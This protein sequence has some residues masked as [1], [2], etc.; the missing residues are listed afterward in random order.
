M[1]VTLIA[2]VGKIESANDVGTYGFRLVIL[3]P[4]NIG[5]PG[6]ASRIEHVYGLN[7]CHPAPW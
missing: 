2:E 1:N 6:N 3:T 4:I 5:A 7:C